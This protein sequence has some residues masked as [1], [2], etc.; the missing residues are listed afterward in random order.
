[1]AGIIA[2]FVLAVVIDTLIMLI[3]RA[4]TPWMRASPATRPARQKAGA[5]G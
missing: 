5:A 1:M 2:I 3:G 4:L